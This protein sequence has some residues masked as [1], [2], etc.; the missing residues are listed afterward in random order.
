VTQ[1][2]YYHDAYLRHFRARIVEAADDGR[3]IYLDQTAFYPTSGGQPSDTG[4]LGGAAVLDVIDEEDRIAHVVDAS[5]STPLAAAEIEAEIDWPRRFDHMQQHTG[6]HLLS[7]V[8]EDL[9]QIPTLSFH[10]GAE[11]STIDLGAPA[12]DSHQMERAEIRCAEIVAEAR[13][14]IVTFDDASA[15]LALRKASERTGTLRI[16]SISGID[17]SACGGTH[18]RTSAEIGPVFLRKT[19][20]VRGTSDWNSPALAR[21]SSCSRR[22]RHASGDLAASLSARG[23]DACAGCS[24]DRNASRRSKNRTRS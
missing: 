20:K 19:E 15:D 13:P 4:T 12:L 2:L 18:V 14:V 5:I 10:L 17:R 22:V 23:T 8:L 7:A 11:T 3:R 1:R 6:Q 16:V 21:P 9:F 24:A